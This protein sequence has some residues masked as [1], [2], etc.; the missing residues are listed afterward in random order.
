MMN[1]ALLKAL[2]VLIPTGVLF[3]A[4]A[5]LFAKRKSATSF[6]QLGGTAA[7]AVVVLAHVCEALHLF[8]SMG[9]GLPDSVGHYVDFY[10]AILAATLFPLGYLLSAL[11]DRRTNS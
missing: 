9:W 1:D 3:F 11:Q 6:L 2:V 5:I 7:L 10:S 8:P 4:A